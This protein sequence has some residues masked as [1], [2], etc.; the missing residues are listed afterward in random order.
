MKQFVLHISTHSSP[1]SGTDADV[2]VT[3]RGSVGDTGK[4]KLSRNGEDVFSKGKVSFLEIQ[5]RTSIVRL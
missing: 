3:L 1:D 4:R 5:L 2:Y